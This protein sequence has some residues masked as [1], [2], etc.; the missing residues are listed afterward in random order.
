MRPAV[1]WQ[2]ANVDASRGDKKNRK[3][4]PLVGEPKKPGKNSAKYNQRL[5]DC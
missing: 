3:E 4:E 1:N 5:N 2:I